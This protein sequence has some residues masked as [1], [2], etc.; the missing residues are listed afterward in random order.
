MLVFFHLPRLYKVESW[1]ES[2]VTAARHP[3]VKVITGI[4]SV[5]AMRSKE[6]HQF[7]TLS[8][9]PHVDYNEMIR[10]NQKRRAEFFKLKGKS[11]V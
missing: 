11:P 9:L 10:E 2:M 5:T 8:V 3:E 4:K 1:M 6:N 7:L